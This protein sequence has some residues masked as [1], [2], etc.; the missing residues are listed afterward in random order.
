[1]TIQDL[2]GKRVIITGAN[3]GIGFET[4]KSL[5]QYGAEVVFAIRNVQKGKQAIERIKKGNP[6]AVL[7]AIELN[8]SDLT[9][10][11]DFTR[12]FTNDYD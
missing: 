7:V 3:S 10:V 12:K 2:N 5:A 1:M 11:R 8:L 9:S 4:A 6:N